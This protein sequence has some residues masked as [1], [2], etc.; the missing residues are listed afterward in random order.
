MSVNNPFFEISLLPYQAPRFDAINDSHYRPAFDEAM[1]L[2]RADIDAIIAQRAAPDFD[3][4]VLALEKSG[5]MLSRVSSVFFAMTSAHTNDYLQALDEQFST[6]LAGLANDIWLN[7]TLFA[8]VEAVWQDREALD[9]ESRRLTEET[10][11]HFVLAGARLNADEK[12]EL[13][14]LNTEAATLTSQ[15]N[16]RLLA[17]NKAG[18]L[19][20]DDVR[21]L[22]GLSAEEMAAAAHAA[23]EKGLKERWLI[24]LLNTTQQPALAALALRETRKKLFSAGWER[25]Q[26]GDENDTRELIRRLTALR[27][28]QAQLL[29]FDNYA[30]WSIAD[31]MAK[32]P[33]AAL[34]FMRGIVPAARGRAALEQADIQKVIDDEQGGFTVQ[35]WDWAFYAER[36]RSAKYALDE[37]QIKPYFALNTVL[38]DGVFWTATQLFGIRFVERFDIP[39]YHPDVRVWEIFDHTGEGMALFYGDFF[40]RDS[41]AGG[42]WMGNFVEQSYEFAARPVIYNVCNYQKP[43]NGQTALISW[44]DVITLF[45]EFGH[46]LHGLF[47]SQRYATLSGT[48]TPRDFVEFPSQ[49]NEHWASHPQVFAH[50]ARHY[51][52]GEPM[53]DALREK[54]LNATQFNKGY[55]MTELLSA[56]LLDMNWHGI[57]EPIE[58]VEAFEA[59]ALK[60]EGLDLPAVPPRYRSSYF[61]HIFGGGYAAGYYAY[62]WTQML[63]D[64]GYQWFVEQ[65]GLTRENGQTFREAILSRGNSTD[66]AELYRNWRGHDPKIEPMLENRGLSA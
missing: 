48:N 28:R 53:P 26:K 61:T 2:K 14:S 49:I 6:E 1:R 27:A 25:T 59:A 42:A 11:Q 29:G 54:M 3:N 23:A 65:D 34:E 36:V 64:D 43:A 10:Y 45:H 66:L 33:E 21:Q 13:K 63:A 37:S 4:T 41:K 57:Q 16:Q 56:A 15:F 52:T 46:T 62:L 40:A 9:A 19:V 18:G 38:E 39:V 24:P 32:T 31:Q 55:D 58:D 50:F 60:K 22:D 12:A 44:D 35:A 7:D 30:S 17:A 5:A 51:Q 8:R 20:V 47:A